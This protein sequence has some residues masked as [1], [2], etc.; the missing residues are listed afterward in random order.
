MQ[1]AML[2]VENRQSKVGRVGRPAC[3]LQL[4]W[5]EF[6]RIIPLIYRRREMVPGFWQLVL[7]LVVILLIFGTKRLKD[8]GGDL[9]GAIKGFKKAMSD[10]EQENIAEQNASEQRTVAEDS[11]QKES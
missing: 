1:G 8:A 11:K 7:V 9:G 10:E 3:Q 4:Y 5:K 6:V 2:T